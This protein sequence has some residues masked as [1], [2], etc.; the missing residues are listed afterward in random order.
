MPHRDGRDPSEPL[1]VALLGTRRRTTANL[2][3][4]VPSSAEVREDVAVSRTA[5]S[6]AD[7]LPRHGSRF[8]AACE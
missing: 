8:Y 5:D 4:T 7:S 3:S 6:H 1:R 2:F